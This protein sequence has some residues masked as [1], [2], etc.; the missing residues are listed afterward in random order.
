MK[1][2]M[3][4]KALSVIAVVATLILAGCAQPP[5]QQFVVQQPDEQ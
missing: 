4:H 5:P 3:R 1:N 2:K